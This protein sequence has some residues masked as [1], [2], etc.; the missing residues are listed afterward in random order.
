MKEFIKQA[1]L[2]F[3]SDVPA[4]ERKAQLILA[5]AG[6]S[7]LGIAA[8]AWPGKLIIV[9]AIAGYIAAACGGM[10]MLLQFAMQAQTIVET[11]TEV[12]VTATETVTA[13]EVPAQ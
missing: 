3:S 12:K 13:T 1:W 9:G 2:R 4:T 11:K 8:I 6:V 10:A 5:S 7:F